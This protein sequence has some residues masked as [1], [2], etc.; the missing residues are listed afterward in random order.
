MSLFVNGHIP[1]IGCFWKAAKRPAHG[2][3]D[4]R[5]PMQAPVRV[6][7]I[8]RDRP[9]D[10][11]PARAQQKY[12]ICQPSWGTERFVIIREAKAPRTEQ[13]L[14]AEPNYAQQA[15]E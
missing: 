15:Q 2:V 3:R 6:R 12:C 9:P 13:V 4:N 11:A 7:S 8:G 10:F 5:S 14:E 1:Q